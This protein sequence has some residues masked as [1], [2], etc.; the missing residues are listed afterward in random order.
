MNEKTRNQPYT[1]SARLIGY[2]GKPRPLWRRA[3]WYLRHP[4]ETARRISGR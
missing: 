2:T 1:G 3:L 4:I